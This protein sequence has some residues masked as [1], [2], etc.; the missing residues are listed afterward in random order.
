[1]QLSGQKSRS[2]TGLRETYNMEPSF[3]ENQH[4]DY[5][6]PAPQGTRQ[7]P[8]KGLAQSTNNF[9]PSRNISEKQIQRSESTKHITQMRIQ[10]DLARVKKC[11]VTGGT[12]DLES[13][14]RT[15]LT[16]NWHQ[17][18]DSDLQ[19]VN[20]NFQEYA[21]NDHIDINHVM[22]HH[23]KYQTDASQAAST[24]VGQNV[25][26]NSHQPIRTLQDDPNKQIS[27]NENIF[28]EMNRTFKGIGASSEKTKR[29][30]RISQE[31]CFRTQ[32]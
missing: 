30:I 11:W 31:S 32:K 23:I 16:Q 20:K 29:L 25:H 6:Q 26:I 2:N 3:M 17:K 1:M 12:S 14:C 27:S 15:D 19:K 18:T 28:F 9:I 8:R 7:L 4:S 22:Q 24:T 5:F 10:S 13:M 21:E